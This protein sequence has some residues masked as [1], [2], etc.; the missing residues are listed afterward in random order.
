MTKA[1][2]LLNMSE[3]MA[4]MMARRYKMTKVRTGMWSIDNP[5]EELMKEIKGKFRPAKGKPNEWIH[6]DLS[7]AKM[8][9]DTLFMQT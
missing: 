4:A 8:K 6:R 1:E 7:Y 3:G 9:G 5:S 2:K